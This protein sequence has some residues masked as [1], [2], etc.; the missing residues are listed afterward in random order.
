MN[1]LSSLGNGARRA[2]VAAMV[3]GTCLLS[4]CASVR[5]GYL[6]TP[7]DPVTGKWA[8]QGSK[9]AAGLIVSGEELEH[10]ATEHFGVIDLAFE[11]KT[12]KWVRVK[13]MA[14][15]FGSEHDPHVF[16]PVGEELKAW[17]TATQQQ[18][19]IDRHNR[20]MALGALALAGM[21][22]AAVSNNRAVSIIGSTVAAGSLAAIGVDSMNKDIESTE[23]PATPQNA[24]Y[25]ESHLLS[26]PFSIPPGLFAKRWVTINTAGGPQ[27]PCVRSVMLD[28]ELESGQ[29][30]RVY[31]T[32]RPGVAR[33]D[34]QAK[35][36][37][38]GRRYSNGTYAND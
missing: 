32:F 25:Y 3:L 9:T 1:T 26:V 28:Y 23:Q 8:E 21:T 35:A 19:L 29:K 2:L 14:L 24:S 38:H 6:G 31:L 15:R 37:R 12:D 13:G 4:G 17:A 5:D 36:C 33:S 18:L 10:L 22:T 7:A 27:V 16:I 34:W 11:N 20:S 30:E